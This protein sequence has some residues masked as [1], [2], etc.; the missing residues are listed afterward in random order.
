MLTFEN[1]DH[2]DDLSSTYIVL[3]VL[4]GIDFKRMKLTAQH[5]LN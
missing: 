4:Y 1:I 2:R 3:D 5:R